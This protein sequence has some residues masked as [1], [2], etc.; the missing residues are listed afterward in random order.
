M[1]F[2]FLIKIE[3]FPERIKAENHK[4]KS[5]LEI[6]ISVMRRKID[7]GEFPCSCYIESFETIAKHMKKELEERGFKVELG[8]SLIGV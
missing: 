8:N 3:E 1:F 6:E 2:H 5:R 4:R 7:E